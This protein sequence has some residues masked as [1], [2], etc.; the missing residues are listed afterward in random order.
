MSCISTAEH[1]DSQ[2]RV[3][4]QGKVIVRQLAANAR[5]TAAAIGPDF[6]AG[7]MSSGG[8]PFIPASRA[9]ANHF[10]MRR[11]YPCGGL[12]MQT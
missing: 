10:A 4:C 11:W 8:V 6:A 7:T 5:E 2:A 3:R 1:Q 12:L 9:E